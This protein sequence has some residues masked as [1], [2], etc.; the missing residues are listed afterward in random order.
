MP[1]YKKQILEQVNDWGRA[2]SMNQAIENIDAIVGG[3]T[4]KETL[5]SCSTRIDALFDTLNGTLDKVNNTLND[6]QVAINKITSEFVNKM[7]TLKQDTQNTVHTVT[8]D[9]NDV[10]NTTGNKADLSPYFNNPEQNERRNLVQTANKLLEI[11]GLL[12]RLTTI[13]K[14]CLVDAVN[15]LDKEIGDI[16][17]ID[18]QIKRDDLVKTLNQVNTLLG[19]V[20]G[21]T[22]T[23]KANLT[24]AINEL[25]KDV[26]NI[27]TIDNQI[28]QTDIVATLNKIN[29]LIGVLSSLTTEAKSSIVDAINSIKNNI[30]TLDTEVIKSATLDGTNINK[31]NNILEITLP[32]ASSTVK[33]GVKI[34]EGIK[35]DAQ[36]M[37]S[38]SKT[39]IELDKVDN[40]SDLEKPISTSAQQEFN[41]KQNILT[42]QG[43]L[44][45]SNNI[46]SIDQEKLDKV[47]K[48][49]DVGSVTSLQTD[50]KTIV[51][52]INELKTELDQLKQS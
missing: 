40:T 21:L 1:T 43:A 6:N 46:V 30:T 25:D 12:E 38:T 52:A 39:D 36:G 7:E 41:K 47:A 33:G 9:I 44:Q 18:V 5:N 42:F 28:K 50:K 20:S 24:E 14:G 16:Q 8:D 49:S 27:D 4:L 26:G 45:C 10:R 23:K 15:E 13:A 11:T 19:T 22:T 34:G 3:Y 37:I 2:S 32:T 31:N 29:N 48:A 17:S 51:E 35:V